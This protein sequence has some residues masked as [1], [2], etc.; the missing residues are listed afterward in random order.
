MLWITPD[1]GRPENLIIQNVLVP[2]VPIRPSVAMD[3]GGGSNEDDLTVKL[4]EIINV[5]VALE[6]NM[7]RNP[8]TKTIMEGESC[9]FTEV[10]NM[11]VTFFIFELIQS[12][13]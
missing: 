4:L 6:L 3:G 9:C 10:Y 5:N 2:P 12:M 7:T 13:S 1:I 11:S 8:Q